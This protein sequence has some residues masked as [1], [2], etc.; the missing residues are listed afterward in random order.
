MKKPK[1]TPTAPGKAGGVS[2]AHAGGVSLAPAGGVSLAPAGGVSPAPAGGVSPA[3]ATG[4][5]LGHRLLAT[6]ISAMERVS[7]Q[8]EV[9]HQQQVRRAADMPSAHMQYEHQQWQQ[10]QQQWQQQRQ[11][12]P[13]V[14]WY[15]QHLPG[16]QLV[17]WTHGQ[18]VC[19]AQ[20][21]GQPAL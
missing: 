7:E 12:Q 15:P 20:L 1:A 18:W 9:I 6:A 8:Q 3:A 13:S 4:I 16:R 5:T 2:L 19:V 21:T 10:D 11:Q 14:I 17:G